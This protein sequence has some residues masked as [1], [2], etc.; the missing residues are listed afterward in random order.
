MSDT[1]AKLIE[2]L[3]YGSVFLVIFAALVYT[4][5]AQDSDTVWVPAR[6]FNAVLEVAIINPQENYA[7][8]EWID[9]TARHETGP[10]VEIDIEDVPLHTQHYTSPPPPVEENVQASVRWIVQPSE[11]AEFN[12]PATDDPYARRVRFA[13]PGTYTLHAKINSMDDDT[14]GEIQSN[15]LTITVLEQ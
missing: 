11:S 13:E 8:G 6:D 10:W 9:L 3:V 7:V 5:R 15:G 12:L 1:K 14:N 4:Y 2:R